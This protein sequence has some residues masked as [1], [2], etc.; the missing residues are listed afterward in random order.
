MALAAPSVGS[1]FEVHRGPGVVAPGLQIDG[2][3]VGQLKLQNKTSRLA[4]PSSTCAGPPVY[5]L[6]LTPDGSYFVPILMAIARCIAGGQRV[7]PATTR[8]VGS[9]TASAPRH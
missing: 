2:P 3:D 9:T 5:L 4:T 7:V 8:S 1:S 6:K